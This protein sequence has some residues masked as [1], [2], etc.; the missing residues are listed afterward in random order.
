V[1]QTVGHSDSAELTGQFRMLGNELQLLES[2]LG[3]CILSVG[4]ADFNGRR[5]HLKIILFVDLWKLRI[6]NSMP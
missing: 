2:S 5:S 4:V 1:S 3:F 6:R